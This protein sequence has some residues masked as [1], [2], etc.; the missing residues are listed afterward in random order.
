MTF[1]INTGTLIVGALLFVVVV[2]VKPMI[3]ILRDKMVWWYIGKYVAND[4]L[5]EELADHEKHITLIYVQDNLRSLLEFDYERKVFTHFLEGYNEVHAATLCISEE[6]LEEMEKF[7]EAGLA[8]ARHRLLEL[9]KASSL[10]SLLLKHYSQDK[11]NSAEEYRDRLAVLY[12][13]QQ[14]RKHVIGWTIRWMFSQMQDNPDAWLEE[15]YFLYYGR[16]EGD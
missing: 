3:L 6:E 12:E 15:D 2:F 4:Y 5:Y 11:K 10:I 13:D 1:S 8:V 9:E 14:G 7:N 16:Y